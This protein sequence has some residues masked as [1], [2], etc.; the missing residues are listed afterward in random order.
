M[1][2]RAQLLPENGRHAACEHRPAAVS[3]PG[4]SIRAAQLYDRYIEHAVLA[5]EIELDS[6]EAPVC[7][8]GVGLRE[9]WPALIVA[10]SYEPVGYGFSPGILVVPETATVF[11]GAGQRLLAYTMARARGDSGWIARTSASGHGR[12]TVNSS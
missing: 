8:F 2:E 10:Q 5:D 4:L 1:L 12:S 3:H 7:F 11:I 9:E 6:A